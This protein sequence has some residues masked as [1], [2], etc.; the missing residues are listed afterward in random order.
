ML[1]ESESR[2][3]LLT[4]KR[5]RA[6]QSSLICK[7]LPFSSLKLPRTSGTTQ[8]RGGFLRCSE[9][10]TA[11]LLGT[12]CRDR[13]RE[14]LMA[15]CLGACY[16]PGLVHDLCDCSSV[17]PGCHQGRWLLHQERHMYSLTEGGWW[18][19]VSGHHSQSLCSR[20]P[21]HCW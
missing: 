8:A 18:V 15:V 5:A 6:G 12:T 14:R 19:G 2:R 20:S 3:G 16:D 13:S 10:A 9:G 1:Q 4:S 17:C 11:I 7:T 21:S